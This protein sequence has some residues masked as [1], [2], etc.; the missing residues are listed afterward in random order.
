MGEP[1]GAVPERGAIGEPSAQ[2]GGTGLSGRVRDGPATGLEPTSSWAERLADMREPNR[3]PA[4]VLERL[5]PAG[6]A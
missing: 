3:A 6:A 4:P 1:P 5:S 2:R